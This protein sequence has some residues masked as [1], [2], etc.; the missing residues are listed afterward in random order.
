MLGPAPA[1]SLGGLAHVQERKDIVGNVIGNDEYA[2]IDVMNWV[3]W[4]NIE[5]FDMSGSKNRN[6]VI[7]GS[8]RIRRGQKCRDLSNAALRRQD[9]GT[10]TICGGGDRRALLCSP[11]G[12]FSDLQGPPASEVYSV[13]ATSILPGG[14][15]RPSGYTILA[16]S[17]GNYTLRSDISSN[18]GAGCGGL[19]PHFS[20][21]VIDGV[22]G[23]PHCG[24]LK[25]RNDG[26]GPR[27][28]S[29]KKSEAISWRIPPSWFPA[30]ISAPSPSRFGFILEFLSFKNPCLAAC[31]SLFILAL[32]FMLIH[33]GPELALP[34]FLTVLPR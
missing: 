32:I 30:N 4:K 7:D 22:I 10:S 24:E 15:K 33:D 34:A 26:E 16:Y 21:L 3:V 12:P 14:I 18:L 13:G 20:K 28:D 25:V 1:D 31:I 8:G 17:S 19:Q 2:P 27:K 29:Y 9:F 23:M 11:F 5:V 6:L